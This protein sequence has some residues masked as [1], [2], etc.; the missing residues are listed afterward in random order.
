MLY[1]YLDEINRVGSASIEEILQKRRLRHKLIRMENSNLKINNLEKAMKDY[2][3][4]FPLVP[5]DLIM[6]ALE[7]YQK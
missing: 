4:N 3:N 5:K 1:D 2:S 7:D 6:K